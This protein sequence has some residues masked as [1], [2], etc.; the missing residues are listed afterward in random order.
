MA[1]HVIGIHLV[2]LGWEVVG[3]A[4]TVP[5]GLPFP[6][7]QGNLEVQSSLDALIVPGQYDAVINCAGVLN[8]DAT[9]HPSR[10]VFLNAVLP[11]W[12]VEHLCATGTRVVHISTDCVFSGKEGHY[13]EEAFK[14]G[15][16][17]YDRSK[18]LGEFTS[19]KDLVLRQSI[20]G[21]DLRPAG[22]GLLNWFL[23][24]Q[25]PIQGYVNA[26]WN[27]ITTLELA[28]GIAAALAAQRSGLFHL[29]APV[30][31]S[32]FDLL[33]LAGEL[34]Q[35]DLAISPVVLPTTIDKTLVIT[36]QGFPTHPP[37]YRTQL[38]DLHRWMLDRAGL[39]PHY[40]L[41]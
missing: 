24:R 29:V 3:V 23:Q 22:I 34:F 21:P 13:R 2:D 30:P 31:I 9:D 6:I 11:H 5:Q 26:M 4:R 33:G 37:D 28:R 39:Y 16:T 1:G 27:G 32:K 19:D 36:R 12:L 38:Q 17:V 40:R 14:D 25:E 10:A 15:D 20:I 41:R 35:K 18:A 8:Q 7:L